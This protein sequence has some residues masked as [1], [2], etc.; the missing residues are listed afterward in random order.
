MKEFILAILVMSDGNFL[1]DTLIPVREE[2][3]ETMQQCTIRREA[4][5]IMHPLED[6]NQFTLCLDIYHF[7]NL[8]Q[9]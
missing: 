4:L 5:L 7:P 8:P 6:P 1:P 9:G 2:T 3:F